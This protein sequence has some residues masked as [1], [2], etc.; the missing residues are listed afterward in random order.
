MSEEGV[1][2]QVQE[3]VPVESQ[4]NEP[5]INETEGHEEEKHEPKGEPL[6]KGV[7][8]R[9][10]RAV[11]QRY[12]AEARAKV[13][14]ERLQALERDRYVPQQQQNRQSQDNSEPTI[15]KFENFDEYVAAKASWI[16]QKQ[17]HEVLTAREQAQLERQQAQERDKFVSTWTERIAK[18]TAEIPDFEDV[19]AASDVPMS[20]NMRAAI[21]DSDV[22][23]LVAYHLA[24]NPEEARKIASM[25]PL[26]QIRALGRIEAKLEAGQTPA[27]VSSNAPPPP[28]TVGGRSSVNRDPDKMSVDEWL[29]WRRGTLKSA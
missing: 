27:T 8:R 20:E 14:E 28:K 12:E 2:E 24:K 23:T 9:I 22:G 18:A 11:R 7:Q 15:D 3:S 25:T 17:I 13:A 10:D 6:P 26:G 29:K 5:E 4:A 21:M 16:A 1:V 19:I